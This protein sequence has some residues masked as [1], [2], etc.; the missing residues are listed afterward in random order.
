MAEVAD[1][2]AAT[3]SAEPPLFAVST[4]KLLVMSMCTI[5]LYQMFWFYKN[6]SLI[7]L[8]QR[9]SIL[10]AA[11]AFFGVI[12]CYSCFSEIRAI[13]QRRGVPD[14]PAAGPLA[15]GWIIA[16]LVW[17][18]PDPFWFAALAAVLFLMPVQV[19]ANAVNDAVAPG[20]DRN[21]RFTGWN[22]AV[23]VPGGLLFVLAVIGAFLPAQA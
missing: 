17:K 21:S 8:H 9:S 23:A 13:G 22:W 1:L 19:Y 11:R 12:F 20:H 16:T 7:K 4:T 3:G 5:G 2:P 15:V 6:W 18:L 14:A 10:P